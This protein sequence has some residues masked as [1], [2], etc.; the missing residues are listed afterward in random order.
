MKKKLSVLIL[1]I[2]FILCI[3]SC[4]KKKDDDIKFYIPNNIRAL[5]VAN[6]LDEG[7][8]YN[9]KKIE[10]I[11]E[12]ESKIEKYV[13][14]DDFTFALCPT[15]TAALSHKTN[16]NVKLLFNTSHASACIV[17][18]KTSISS[19]TSLVGK[20]IYVEKGS[21]SKTLQYI[22]KNNEISY[23]TSELKDTSVCIKEV[24]DSN[25][26]VSLF[27][28]TDE[29]ISLVS[30]PYLTKISNLFTV[31]IAID[32]QNEYKKLN[33]Y[34]YPD[35]SI[36]VNSTFAEENET[37]IYS[38]Y[39]TLS[40]CQSYLDKNHDNLNVF[41]NNL[42]LTNLSGFSYDKQTIERL[43]VDVTKAYF[44]KE[45]INNYVENFT[46]LKLDDDY[47]YAF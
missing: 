20:T 29:V 47:Y 25:Q 6:L 40:G 15:T 11:F 27:T 23:S 10:F 34:F 18:N 30:E 7:I 12:E 22:L 14:N 17:S 24:N 2:I 26:L 28:S 5:G 44:H 9:D 46:N 1:S 45:N 16:S 31:N 35:S 38:L 3:T 32:I 4:R 41:F 13:N 36:V 43:R 19:L 42:D 39:S 8:T 33:N 37:F 21:I